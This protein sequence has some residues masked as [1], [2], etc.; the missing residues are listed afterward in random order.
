M[1]AAL[2]G[3]GVSCGSHVQPPTSPMLNRQNSRSGYSWGDAMAPVNRV[4]REKTNVETTPKS[5]TSIKRSLLVVSKE[6][7]T[8]ISIIE[9]TPADPPGDFFPERADE[10]AI[11]ANQRDETM[12][13][14]L[15]L[16]NCLLKMGWRGIGMLGA[17]GALGK[18]WLAEET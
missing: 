2:M 1:G 12:L 7:L 4:L 8:P 3:A 5:A 18:D 6:T 17:S 11:V 10:S 9:P 15:G 14:A 16:E 13:D